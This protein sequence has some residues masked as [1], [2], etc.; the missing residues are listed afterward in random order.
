MEDNII[1]QIEYRNYTIKIVYDDS[2]WNPREDDNLG[3]IF[4]PASQGGHKY[5]LNES[6]IQ[7]IEEFS[8][9]VKKYKTIYLPLYI[10]DHSGITFNTTGFSCP[11]DSWQIGFIYI[12]KEKA[13][14]ELGWKII[15]KNR[16]KKLYSYLRR[17]VEEFDNYCTGNCC[18]YII[19]YN[20]EQIESCYNFLGDEGQKYAISESK[21]IIDNI[22]KNR[23]I[24]LNLF[25][26]PKEFRLA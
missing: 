24:Q 3:T 6:E 7:T 10:Y 21:A 26:I 2:P 25:E 15:T 1:E 13:R 22:I 18:G 19:E 20:G 5:G 11:W 14:K 4:A 12:D 8:A 16:I 9:H 17:E 23:D